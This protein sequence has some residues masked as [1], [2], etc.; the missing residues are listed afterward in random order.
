MMRVDAVPAH[1]RSA[2]REFN[3]LWGRYVRRVIRMLQVWLVAVAWVAAVDAATSDGSLAVRSAPAVFMLLLLLFLPRLRRLRRRRR[4]RRPSWRQ[5][6]KM[7]SSGLD[8]FTDAAAVV[9]GQMSPAEA[10]ARNVDRVLK[11][12]PQ[13]SNRWLLVSFTVG[14]PLLLVVPH[15][16]GVL[17]AEVVAVP[18]S[19]WIWR[20]M[21]N[22]AGLDKSM[23]ENLAEVVDVDDDD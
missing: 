15:W 14:L 5:Q 3:A 16:L 19:V 4:P 7:L 8:A 23:L 9:H 13:T 10:R 11:M 21:N 18:V 2:A 1:R 20:E 12:S 22:V 17:A 6:R